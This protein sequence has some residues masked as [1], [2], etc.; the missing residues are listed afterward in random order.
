[1]ANANKYT[2]CIAINEYYI[3]LEN[4]MYSNEIAMNLVIALLQEYL[5]NKK[6]SYL[7]DSNTPKKIINDLNNIVELKYYEDKKE[8]IKDNNKYK[9]LKEN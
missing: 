7:T 4:E 1:M 3:K 6:F 2:G 8:D 5:G 9:P